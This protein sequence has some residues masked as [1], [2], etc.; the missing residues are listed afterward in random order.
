[1]NDAVK[2]W[3]RCYWDQRSSRAAAAQS[4]PRGI[5]LTYSKVGLQS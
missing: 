4:N 3:N 2:I 1:M 5:W